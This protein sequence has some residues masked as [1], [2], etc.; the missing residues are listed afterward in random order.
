MMCEAKV[1]ICSEMNT[2][3]IKTVCEQNVLVKYSNVKPA[4]ASRIQ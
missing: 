1:T 2:K 3:H 4:G